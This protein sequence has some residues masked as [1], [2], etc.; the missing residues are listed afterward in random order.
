[1]HS[2]HPSA[3]KSDYANAFKQSTPKKTTPYKHKFEHLSIGEKSNIWVLFNNLTSPK[4]H[5]LI[6]S[7]HILGHVVI[8]QMLMCL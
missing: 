8:F 2:N 7:A 4:E 3:F 5:G 6:I 1:M